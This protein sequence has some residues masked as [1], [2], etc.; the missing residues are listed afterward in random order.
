ML[1]Q[2]VG[3]LAVAPQAE[4]YGA[5]AG[6]LLALIA[7]HVAEAQGIGKQMVA[8]RMGREDSSYIQRIPKGVI[9]P[10]TL[11]LVA[12]ELTALR[13]L[14]EGYAS[15]WEPVVVW[16]SVTVG[17]VSVACTVAIATSEIRRNDALIAT[18]SHAKKWGPPIVG[19]IV[20]LVASPLVWGKQFSGATFSVYGTCLEGGCGLKQRSGPGR[21]FREIDSSDRLPD[22]KQV[23][24]V[25]QAPGPPPKGY[26]SRVWDQL[27]NGLY[28][29]DAFVDT[30]NRSGGFSE[31]LPRC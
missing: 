27:P 6:T 26:K 17:L 1:R 20:G 24:V 18:F 30:P 16:T 22:D 2:H 23:H 3:E 10:I 31:G 14:S 29:S 8:A 13:V 21:D 9:G 7:L 12:G 5:A 15:R 19:V 28:V 4:F 11:Y 25:C